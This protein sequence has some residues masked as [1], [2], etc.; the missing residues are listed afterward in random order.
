MNPSQKP[1]T[2]S[3]YSTVE[4]GHTFRVLFPAGRVLYVEIPPGVFENDDDVVGPD[5]VAILPQNL[6]PHVN[7]IHIG[8]GFDINFE[9]RELASASTWNPRI[10]DILNLSRV[11]RYSERVFETVIDGTP[12]I[13]KYARFEHEI[14]DI[15]N[16]TDIYRRLHGTGIG[17]RFL[18]HLAEEG[19]VIGFAMEKV[20]GRRANK[21]DYNAVR[22]ALTKLHDLG[23]RHGD[24]NRNNFVITERGAVIIDFEAGVM[25]SNASEEMTE[26][27]ERLER[28]DSEGYYPS[29]W[30]RN[31]P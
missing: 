31:M 23:I 2:L 9:W 4:D 1:H 29:A 26:L 13:G 24:I 25:D 3:T 17:P 5:V 21:A 27:Q 19:R 12:A 15:R 7:I 20:I 16:E 14:D 8:P 28:D 22:D 10:I 11:A 30:K 6:P 18:G